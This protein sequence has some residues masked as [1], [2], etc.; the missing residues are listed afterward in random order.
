MFSSIYALYEYVSSLGPCLC[1]FIR[2]LTLLR[3][4]FHASAGLIFCD[5]GRDFLAQLV[6]RWIN[7]SLYPVNKFI[8][9]HFQ[10]HAEVIFVYI[11][12]LI[13]KMVSYKNDS[14]FSSSFIFFI[15]RSA[16]TKRRDSKL[17]LCGSF[18]LN[19]A[20]FSILSITYWL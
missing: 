20:V 10:G 4:C 9:T 14:F 16:Y 13:I 1:I 17:S 8:P 15:L 19:K 11:D 7:S 6:H 3:S 2:K 5:S 12:K 18:F